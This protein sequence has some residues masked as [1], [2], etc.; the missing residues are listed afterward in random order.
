ERHILWGELIGG[1]LIVGCSVALV[2]SLWQ[3]LQQIPM[4]PFLIL[5]ALTSALFGIGRY[6]FR[7]WKL[8]ATSRGLLVIALLLVPLNFMVLAGLSAQTTDIRIELATK[9]AAIALFAWLVWR[10]GTLLFRPSEAVLLAWAIVGA[11]ISP[12]PVPRLFNPEGLLW[13]LPAVWAAVC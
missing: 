3:S 4:F 7:R 9:A 5:A 12:L 13:F 8:E 2:L 10:A 11:A 1:L 6:T